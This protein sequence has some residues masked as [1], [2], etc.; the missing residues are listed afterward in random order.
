M[1]VIEIQDK[2]FPALLS[3]ITGRGEEETGRVEAAVKAVLDAVHKTATGPSSN[4]PESS[5]ERIS[6]AAS[7]S[8][9]GR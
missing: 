9:P 1:Q 3:S 7:R 5:T 4:T 2:G 8:P 6:K